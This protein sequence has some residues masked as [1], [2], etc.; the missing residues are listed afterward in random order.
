M[1]IC[2]AHSVYETTVCAVY[3][4]YSVNNH[5]FSICKQLANVYYAIVMNLGYKKIT[6]QH[7]IECRDE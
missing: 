7:K 2:V 6:R 1:C 3:M 5:M 4:L